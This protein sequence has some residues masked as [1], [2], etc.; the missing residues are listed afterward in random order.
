[1]SVRENTTVSEVEGGGAT[2]SSSVVV[3]ILVPFF[4]LILAGLGFYLYKQ[5]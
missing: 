5:R 2:S 4:T 3:S 1:M